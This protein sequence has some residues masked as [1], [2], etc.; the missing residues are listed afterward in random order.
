MESTRSTKRVTL[1]CYVQPVT[2]TPERK[3]RHR[4][5]EYWRK[6]LNEVGLDAGLIE[7]LMW[8]QSNWREIIEKRTRHILGQDRTSQDRTKEDRTSQEEWGGEQAKCNRNRRSQMSRSQKND[9]HSND[10]QFVNRLNV[11]KFLYQLQAEKFMKGFIE[12]TDSR[13]QRENSAIQ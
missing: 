9:E 6:I 5:L 10:H 12:K 8:D 7:N 13:K 4:T 2:P 3:P 11:V 1:G